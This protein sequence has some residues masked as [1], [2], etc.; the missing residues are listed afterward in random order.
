[1][2]T[3]ERIPERFTNPFRPKK[4]SDN[5]RIVS[6]RRWYFVQVLCLLFRVFSTPPI[7]ESAQKCPLICLSR[8]LFIISEFANGY[9]RSSSSVNPAIMWLSNSRFR[10]GASSSY[11]SAR[12]TRSGS[13]GISRIVL[14][15]DSVAR[16]INQNGKFEMWESSNRSFTAT[17]LFGRSEGPLHTRSLDAFMR[18]N[19]GFQ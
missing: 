2:A 13:H 14:C 19:N 1:M 8:I 15:G 3:T 10:S 5:C 7:T 11:Q 6:F 16:E 4:Y 17:T 9:I 12:G 18:I